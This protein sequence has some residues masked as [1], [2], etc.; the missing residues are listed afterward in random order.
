[1]E[2]LFGRMQEQSQFTL[3]GDSFVDLLVRCLE[4]PS[5]HGRAVTVADRHAE[6]ARPA[7]RAGATFD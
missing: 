7:D 6:L 5:H 4:D 2:A 1:V 3:E